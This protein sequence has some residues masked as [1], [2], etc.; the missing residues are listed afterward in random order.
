M[1]MVDIIN[2]KNV[3]FF[4]QLL[5]QLSIIQGEKAKMWFFAVSKDLRWGKFAKIL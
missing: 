1:K 2:R 4:I 3:Q 5:I